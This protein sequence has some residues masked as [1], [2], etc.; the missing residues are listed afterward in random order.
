MREQLRLLINEAKTSFLNNK[1]AENSGKKS[2]YKIVDSFLL[3]K[4]GV[5]LPRH[6]SLPDLLDQFSQFFQNKI[7]D[8]RTSL[9]EDILSTG[10]LEI[11]SQRCS[12]SYSAFT[13][14]KE[15]DVILLIKR[16]PNKS[17]TRDPIPTLLVKRFAGI[18]ARSIAKLINTSLST[19]VLPEEM[20]IAFV[21]PVLKKL[22]LCPDVLSNYRPV[23]NLS[24]L[25]KL[26]ERAAGKQLMDYLE[27]SGLLVPVQSAYRSH[28][29]TETALLKVMDDLLLAVDSK[30][31]ALLVLLDLSAAFDTIDHA[32]LLDRMSTRFNIGGPALS[33]FKSYLSDRVQSISLFGSTS[34]KV[35]LNHGVPQGSV[36]GPILFTMY[37][38]PLHQIALAHGVSSHFYADDTQFLKSFRIG[39]DGEEQRKAFDCLS[40]C[41]ASTKR[42]MTIN[43]LKLNEDKT[44][45]LMVYSGTGR[46]KP[47]NLSLMAAGVSITLSTT[48]RNLGVLFDSH[49]TM[50]PKTRLVC[51]KA[52]FHLRRIARIR[53]Y[54]SDTATAQLIHTFVTS[55]L[56]SGNSLL[57]GIP[58]TR[59]SKLQRVQ[60]SA[61][62]LLVRSK[63]ADPI[64]PHLK[65]TTLAS[66]LAANPVQDSHSDL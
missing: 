42:W 49:L 1:I 65:K 55:L 31:A 34:K 20:K 25:S 17:S 32:I 63:R 4:P 9:D 48:S 8:I 62:R 56:D 6:D 66:S 27:S 43:K 30:N 57:A 3:K 15:E 5:K 38:S 37:T 21:T 2:I 40:D 60:N 47:L 18:L 45:A 53:K 54:L 16:S 22:D 58:S 7:S 64:T 26:V 19:G 51:K 44:D 14:V 10:E 39:D 35:S 33:W 11:L 46:A 12:C 29:S 28:H 36:L 23:S 61:A 50:E 52:Y 24:F 13:P 59:L 41:I